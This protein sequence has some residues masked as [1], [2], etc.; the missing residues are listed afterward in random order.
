[1]CHITANARLLIIAGAEY[2]ILK[3]IGIADNCPKCF[4]AKRYCLLCT[5][6]NP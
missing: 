4:L 1:M 3:E 6:G 5:A 2:S